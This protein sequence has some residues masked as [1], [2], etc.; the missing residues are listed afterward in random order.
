[1]LFTLE[2]GNWYACEL[3]GDEF[4]DDCCSYSP[5]RVNGITPLKSG[6]GKFRL[7]FYHANYPEGVRDKSYDLVMLEHGSR[8]LLAISRKHIPART[9]Q[10]YDIDWPWMISHFSPFDG[11]GS[12]DIQTWLGRNV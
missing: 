12:E 8:Y 10:I 4:D 11:D 9:M 2:P 5:I 1:M 7:D 6:R 3:I